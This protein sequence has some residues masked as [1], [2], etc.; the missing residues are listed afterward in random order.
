MDIP[1]CTI[2]DFYFIT[3]I[4]GKIEGIPYNINKRFEFVGMIE[5]GGLT[6]LG[7]KGITFTWCTQGKHMKEYGRY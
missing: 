3:S 7:Y 1:W 5:A 4:Q 6:N 2:G